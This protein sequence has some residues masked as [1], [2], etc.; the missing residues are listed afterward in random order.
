MADKMEKKE[1]VFDA[2]GQILGRLASKIAVILQGKTSAAYNPRLAG[3]SRVI[4]KNAA[5]VKFSGN[6]ET[7]KEYYHHTGYQGH[8]RAKPVHE[9]RKSTPERILHYA[10]YNMLPKNKLRPARMKRL[11]IEA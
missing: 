2:D 8:L 3:T 4:V 10:V 5:K 1:Y 7:Q 9:M 11:K 6:K